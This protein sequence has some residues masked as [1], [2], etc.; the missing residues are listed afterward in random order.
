MTPT[1]RPIKSESPRVELVYRYLFKVSVCTIR[2]EKTCSKVWSLKQTKILGI[3]TQKR[4][5]KSKSSFSRHSF[6]PLNMLYCHF[7]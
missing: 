7:E 6:Y 3:L 2:V 1:S 5:L 4:N